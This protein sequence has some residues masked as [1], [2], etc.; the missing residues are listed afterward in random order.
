MLCP[1]KSRRA[2]EGPPC[3]GAYGSSQVIRLPN[4]DIHLSDGQ[5]RL[6]PFTEADLDTVARWFTDPEVMYYADSAE[7]PSYT[8]D[9]ME[10]IYRGVAEEWGGLLFIIESEAG[11]VIGETWLQQMNLERGREQPPD[12]A[13]RIDIAIGEKEYWGR[14]YG[15]RAVRLL[16]RYAF[17][18]LAADRLAGMAVFEFNERSLRMFRACG[19][20]LVRRVP[21]RIARGGTL[22]A[23]LDLEITREEWLEG[24]QGG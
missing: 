21:D 19:M 20:R 18:E 3:T 11:H 6:R 24:R 13:W 9:E 5:V 14:G 16:M 22:F 15:R 23:E 17:E 2:M 10:G 4:H 8:R 1:Y 7:H 12:R